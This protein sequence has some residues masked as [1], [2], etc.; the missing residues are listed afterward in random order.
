[1]SVPGADDRFR[2]MVEAQ[3]E[4]I[5]LAQ[6]DGRLVYVN[7][8]Y[9]RRFGRSPAELIGTSLFDLV[10]EADRPAVRAQFDALLRDG[11]PRHGENR[12]LTTGGQEL[13]VAWSNHCHVEGALTLVQSVGRD[14]SAE[15]LGR[16]ELQRQS[17]V[18]SAVAEAIP[19]TVVV[20]DSGG[21]YRF[22][23][24][25]FEAYCGLPREQI[26]GRTAMDVLGADEVARRRPFMQ[27]AFAGEPVDFTLDYPGPDG[28][29][30]LALSCVPLKVEGLV[31]GFVGISQDITR[32]RREE[33]RLKHLAQRDSLT[34]LLNRAGFEAE[35]ERLVRE[36]GGAHLALLYVDLDR[37]KPVNDVH[38]HP[39]G[40]RVLQLFAQRLHQVVRDTDR[41]ARLGGDEFALL[42]PGMREIAHV[43]RVADKVLLTAHEP[44][45]IG[46]RSISIG[47]SVGVA[48]GVEAGGAWE[49]LLAR[50][51]T[52]LYR[53]KQGGRGRQA[54][55]DDTTPPS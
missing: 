45:E 25:A 3:A 48:L 52:M 24:G 26:L 50:A 7:A 6:P 16:R 41:V 1:M 40:D 46:R 22:V 28:P 42:L 39:V 9:A 49:D 55:G 32:Q 29:R 33:Q 13:W 15:R 34:G 44:F 23:N 8:A 38:G 18:L 35:I 10:L 5:S 21:R 11:Q 53:A 14:I 20:V 37:F 47:A 19:T 36:G 30:Y 12:M 4:F 31:D 2:A 27:R 54:D 43:R 51:D 17:D